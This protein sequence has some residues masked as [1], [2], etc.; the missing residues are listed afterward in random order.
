MAP[1]TIR[2]PSVSLEQ[3]IKI[4]QEVQRAVLEFPEVQMMVSKIGRT[5]L[6]NDPQEPNESDSVAMLHPIDTWTTASTMA[7][8]KEQVRERLAQ[9]PGANY[10]DQP[11]DP[12]T[13]GRIDFGGARGGDRQTVRA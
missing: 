5:E 13:G 7:E 9:V 10:S 1:L 2:L 6:A 3:S 12:A 4:E 8:L 11:A